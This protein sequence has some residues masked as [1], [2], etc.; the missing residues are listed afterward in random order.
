MSVSAEVLQ[1]NGKIKELDAEDLLKEDE[2]GMICWADK[3]IKEG[4]SVLYQELSRK[5][6]RKHKFNILQWV[7]RQ[8]LV[9]CT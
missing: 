4:W 8:S 6:R 1:I 3:T 2:V 7:A 9:H 5:K